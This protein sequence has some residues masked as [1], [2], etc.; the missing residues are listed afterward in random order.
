MASEPLAKAEWGGSSAVARDRET[1][2]MVNLQATAKTI[3]IHTYIMRFD[4]SEETYDQKG[5]AGVALILSTPY[6]SS[7]T[8]PGRR[9]FRQGWRTTPWL[10]SCWFTTNND[11]ARQL[12]F[13]SRPF[14]AFHPPK[15]TAVRS[16]ASGGGERR[17]V[18][19]E[20]IDKRHPLPPSR[21]V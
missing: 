16:K 3:Y 12:L 8:L 6:H 18:R 17:R 2:K 10:L 7:R 9:Q 20:R 19:R 13:A 5:M 21:V 11:S 1:K 15:A 4:R 14:V